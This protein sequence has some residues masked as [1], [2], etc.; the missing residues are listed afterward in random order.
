M[1][2]LPAS[3]TTAGT[4]YSLLFKNRTSTRGN[5]S[6]RRGRFATP[7]NA[8]VKG[9]QKMRT[10]RDCVSDWIWKDCDIEGH[11]VECYRQVCPD[12]G[13]TMSRD[14]EDQQP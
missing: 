6:L 2:H 13:D 4:M 9:G 12:C 8:R 10:K 11:E 14:C 3:G 5:A 1:Q 7:Q